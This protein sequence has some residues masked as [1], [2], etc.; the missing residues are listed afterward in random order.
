MVVAKDCIR[1][2]IINVSLLQSVVQNGEQVQYACLQQIC[3][4][5]YL[6]ENVVFF[7][8]D[9]RWLI[10]EDLAHGTFARRILKIEERSR[11][12]VHLYEQ[13]RKFS[14]QVK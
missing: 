10:I 14:S 13:S 6:E 5:T 8:C 3:D 1:I 4:D 11:R 9:L 7:N 12:N 2:V